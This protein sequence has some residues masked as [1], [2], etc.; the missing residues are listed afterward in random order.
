MA[1]TVNFSKKAEKAYQKL[2]GDVRR[3]VDQ[4]LEYLRNTPRG[5]DTK[6]L[7]GYPNAYRTRV[8]DYRIIYEIEDAALI[9]WILDVGGRGGI[10][11]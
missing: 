5:P 8:G 11:K 2:P 7:Q 9:V 1:Y 10:Y 6:K 4:K 3:R